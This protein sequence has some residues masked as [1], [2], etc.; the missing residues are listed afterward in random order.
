MIKCI[1][2]NHYSK[3]T[4]HTYLGWFMRFIAFHHFKDPLELSDKDIAAYLEYLVFKRKVSSSTQALALNSIIFFYKKVIEREVSDDIQFFRSKKP[5]RLPVVLSKNEVR[6]LLNEMSNPIWRLMAHLLY[7]CGMRLMEA[8]RLRIL[9]VDF[10]YHQILIRNAKGK[11][12]RVVPIPDKLINSLRDQIKYASE[13]HQ[14]DIKTGFGSVYIPEALSR[15]YPNAAFELRWQYVFPAM[16]ISA[17]P[18]SGIRR[19]H[20]IHETGL[21]KNIKSSAERVGI[22][23]RVTCHVLRHSFATHL[24]ENGYDIRT[25]QELLGHADVSTTMIYTHVLNKPGVT[26]TSPLDM[27]DV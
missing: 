9:D 20:H 6:M 26:V 14:D 27:L 19:R 10:D 21:Q 4:E 23:K 1:R 8:V 5:K 2:T 25:V 7:G 16:T 13:L 24:L 15:K 11:K 3:R 18:L 17:D 22:L 12:D